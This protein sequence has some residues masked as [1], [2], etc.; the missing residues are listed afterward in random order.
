MAHMSSP[1]PS[2]LSS[3]FVVSHSG[4]AAGHGWSS[5]RGEGCGGGRPRVERQR[6]SGAAEQS[7]GGGRP[8][9]EHPLQVVIELGCGFA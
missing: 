7:S 1:L 3:L 4:V 8:R 5:G 2:S 6:R 9:V